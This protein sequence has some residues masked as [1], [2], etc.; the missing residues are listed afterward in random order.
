MD[1]EL[2]MLDTVIATTNFPEYRVLAG[3]LGTIVEEPI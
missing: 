1:I 3:D 2:R